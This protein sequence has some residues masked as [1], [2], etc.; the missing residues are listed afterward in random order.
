MSI[1]FYFFFIVDFSRYFRYHEE[2]FC[3]Q[4]GYITLHIVQNTAFVFSFNDNSI[5]QNQNRE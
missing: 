1:F 2:R 4:N 3:F 5:V